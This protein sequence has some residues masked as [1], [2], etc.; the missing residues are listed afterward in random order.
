MINFE[1]QRTMAKSDKSDTHKKEM[2]I[3]LEARL[4][5]VTNACKDVGIARST[6]Y[7]WYNGDEDYKAAVD[8]ISELTIDFVEDKLHQR[9]NGVEGVKYGA[10][11]SPVTYEIP[12]DTTAIIFFL[13]TRAKHRGY[14]E[15]SQMDLNVNKLGLDAEETYE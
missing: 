8:D 2:L 4:G 9:I 3:A 11:G 10:D 15:K 6:H 12:P 1:E 13:K 14:I 5:N 7:E